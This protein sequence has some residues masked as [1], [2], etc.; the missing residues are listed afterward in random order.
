MV[1]SFGALLYSASSFFRMESMS[2]L[3]DSLMMVVM[4]FL[5][6]VGISGIHGGLS[7]LRTSVAIVSNVVSVDGRVEAVGW[8]LLAR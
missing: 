3:L 4:A 5:Q 7:S 6:S 8:D 1:V 2:F